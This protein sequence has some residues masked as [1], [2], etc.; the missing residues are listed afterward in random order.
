[1]IAGEL[2][3]CIEKRFWELKEALQGVDRKDIQNVLKKFKSLTT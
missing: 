1:M 3:E 2:G